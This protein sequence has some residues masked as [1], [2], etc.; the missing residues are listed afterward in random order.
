MSK[1]QRKAKTIKLVIAENHRVITKDDVA[2]RAYEL[3]IAR[4]HREGHDVADWLEAE[5]QLKAE[6]NQKAEAAKEG[7]C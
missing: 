2:R 1:A 5:R 4:G 7:W 6:S 3:F